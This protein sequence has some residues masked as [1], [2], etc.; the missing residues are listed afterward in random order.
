MRRGW[1]RWNG[2]DAC[3]VPA[4]AIVMQNAVAWTILESF[5]EKFG[6]D[7]LLEVKRNYDG[8]VDYVK[9]AMQ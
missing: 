2:P 1:L 5:L 4:A 9:A 3:A 6:G 8:Y 7:S